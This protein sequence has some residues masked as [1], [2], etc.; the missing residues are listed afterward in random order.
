MVFWSEK[1]SADNPK[2]LNQ[3]PLTAMKLVLQD[4]LSEA[5]VYGSDR[6]AF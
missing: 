2:D 6:P 3:I 4:P 5:C 1:I